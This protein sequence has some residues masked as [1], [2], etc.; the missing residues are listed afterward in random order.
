[1]FSLLKA[2]SSSPAPL[3]SLSLQQTV[4]DQGKEVSQ[5]RIKHIPLCPQHVPFMCSQTARCELPNQHGPFSPQ[6]PSSLGK[7]PCWGSQPATSQGP[8][9][10]WPYGGGQ[11]SH[12][13]ARIP[14]AQL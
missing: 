5:L 9:V 8:L 12:S 4:Q 10:G 13:N 1:M 3:L 6:E 7:S 11:C 2:S 14:Q